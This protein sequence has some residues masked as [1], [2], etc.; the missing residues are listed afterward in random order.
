MNRTLPFVMIGI[1]AMFAVSAI[2]GIDPYLNLDFED[3]VPGGS[4]ANWYA[5]G[6]GYSGEIST[7]HPH[8]GEQCLQLTRVDPATTGF[9]VGTSSFPVS[10]AAG[11]KVTYSGWIRTEGVT[12]GFAGL[13][14]RVDGPD[15][16]LAFDNM[17]DRGITG[18]TGWTRCVVELEVDTTATHINF[19]CLLPGDGTAWFDDLQVELDGELFVQE[20]PTPFAANA[21]QVGWIAARA[22]PFDTDDPAADPGDLSFMKYLVGDAHIV[23]LGEATHGTAEFFRMKHRLLRYLVREMGFTQFAI[24]ATMPEAERLNDYVQEG[25]GDPAE[26]IAG[27]Y[28]WTWKTEEVLALVEW[29]REYNAQGGHIEFH[30]I[31]LQMPGMAMRTALDL[32]E[33]HAPDLATDAAVSYAELRGAIRA[34]SSGNNWPPQVSKKATK[35]VESVPRQLAERRE[36]LLRTAPEQEVDWGIQNAR[37]VAQYADMVSGGPG[38]RDQYMADNAEWLLQQSGPDTRMVIWAHN[39]HVSRNGY[40]G[41]ESMGRHLAERHGDDLVVMGFCFAEGTYT[42]FKRDEGLGSWGTSA[43]RPGT[44]EWAFLQTGQPRLILDLR[45]AQPGSAESGWVFEP[46][47]LRSIGAMAMDDAFSARILAEEFDALIYFETSTPSVPLENEKPS[48]WAMW[49]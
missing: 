33:A 26:L 3:G 13:W 2:A 31:D 30:G 41:I 17:R 12:S 24:E 14:W 21:E 40:S 25:A 20:R 28:F 39:G 32:I 9:G 47:E 10:I 15:G 7:D 27:M 44:A 19:G 22:H 45:E 4:P 23:A 34:A 29:M 38:L 6:K 36:D 11:H 1:L 8:S 49:E 42:A 46:L 43:A 35:A 37:L 48:P 16:T 5:G 18:D